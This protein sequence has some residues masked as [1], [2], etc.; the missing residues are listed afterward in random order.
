MSF[1]RKRPSADE[2]NVTPM[3]DVLLVLLIFFIVTS[4]L[5]KSN[6]LSIELPRA[7]GDAAEAPQ[8]AVELLVA[9]DGSYSINGAALVNR[10]LSTL[11]K[12]L[13]EV[14]AEPMDTPLVIAADA[15]TNHQAVVGAMDVAGQLGFRHLSI[16][17]QATTEPAS[18]AATSSPRASASPAPV[19]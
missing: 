18:A 17:T 4:S 19:R 5:S 3:I 12:A 14:A 8:K 15:G 7:D 16:A 9:K 11:R 6:H 1:R 10:E 13:H 2:I